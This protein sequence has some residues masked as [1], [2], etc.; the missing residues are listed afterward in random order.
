MRHKP[1]LAYLL[2]ICA[3]A[4]LASVWIVF[5]I[6]LDLP[7]R[8]LENPMAYQKLKTYAA[9]IRHFDEEGI[10]A[11]VC[12]DAGP[13]IALQTFTA[14]G[15]EGRIMAA[16]SVEQA[17]FNPNESTP[18]KQVYQ[19]RL[20]TPVGERAFPVNVLLLDGSWCIEEPGVK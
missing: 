5:R 7:Q 16:Q 4:L 10:L 8:D 6:F 11:T 3:V 18:I 15:E 2:V 20:Q 9:V 1:L 19:M 13:E 17:S 12:P 14:L